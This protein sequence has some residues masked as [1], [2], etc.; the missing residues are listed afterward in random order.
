VDESGVTA[1]LFKGKKRKVALLPSCQTEA[2][3]QDG[4]D[5]THVSGVATVSLGLNFLPTLFL[6]V[7]CVTLKYSDLG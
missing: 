4:R 5:V 1:Q 2:L 6:M 7:S 3:F